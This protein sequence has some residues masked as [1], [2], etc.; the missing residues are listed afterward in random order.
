[1]V[2]E[3]VKPLAISHCPH[4]PI[5]QRFRLHPAFADGA[6]FSAHIRRRHG[7]IL[8]MLAANQSAPRAPEDY[9]PQ[10]PP[11]GPSVAEL[12]I[13]DADLSSAGAAELLHL[14]QRG[15]QV[16]IGLMQAMDEAFEHLVTVGDADGYPLMVERFKPKFAS[17]DGNLSRIATH[18]ERLSQPALASVVKQIA[19]KGPTRL[20]AKLEEQVLRQRL[21][22]TDLDDEERPTMKA[23][24][25]SVTAGLTSQN[26]AVEEQLEELRAELADLDEE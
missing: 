4:G 13:P 1:M 9:K 24:C 6:I 25:A 20:N 7:K 14:T 26:A 21:S 8:P 17:L 2:I 12:S 3:W 19:A 22:V 11:E 15:E 5:L 18:L 23:K 16:Y 10:P